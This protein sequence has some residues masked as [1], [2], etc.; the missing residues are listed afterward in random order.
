MGIDRHKNRKRLQRIIMKICLECADGGH[1]DEMI[2]I[3]DAFE[4]NELCFITFDTMT[5]NDLHKIARTIYVKN[6]KGV[7]D[8]ASLPSPLIWIYAFFY[9]INMMIPSFQ[10]IRQERPDVIVSTGGPVTIPLS[11]IGKLLGVRIIYIESLTRINSPSLTGRFIYPITDLFLVQWESMLVY[12]KKA[13]YW[14][15]VI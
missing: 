9:I 7:I 14:G 8:P 4:G 10:I 3:L 12:Y 11:Y 2:S 15:K 13:K 6:F 1:L 5:T